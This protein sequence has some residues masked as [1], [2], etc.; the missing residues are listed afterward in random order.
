MFFLFQI[1]IQGKKPFLIVIKDVFYEL[2]KGWKAFFTVIIKNKWF[3]VT[4]NVKRR[5]APFF[6]V[7]VKNKCFFGDGKFNSGKKSF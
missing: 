7:I 1:K 2:N 5:K 6:I 4:R 3:F